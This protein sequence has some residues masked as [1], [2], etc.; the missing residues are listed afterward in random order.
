ME[1]YNYAVHI[2]LLVKTKAGAKENCN[3]DYEGFDYITYKWRLLLI[4]FNTIIINGKDG[5][6]VG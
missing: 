4:I 3:H 2:N 6:R 5:F 1:P